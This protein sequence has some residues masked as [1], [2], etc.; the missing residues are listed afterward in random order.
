MKYNYDTEKTDKKNTFKYIYTIKIQ[1][2]KIFKRFSTTKIDKQRLISYPNMSLHYSILL[3]VLDSIQNLKK[4]NI[5]I[6]CRVIS[7]FTLSTN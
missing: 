5:T 2:Q 7:I 1:I 6:M 4:I 3:S